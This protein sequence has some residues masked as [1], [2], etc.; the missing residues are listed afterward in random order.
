MSEYSVSQL[1]SLAGVSVRTLHYYDELGLLQPSGRS[2]AG[3]RVYNHAD[4][5]RLQQVLF[6]RELGV[7]LAEIP[8]LLAAPGFDRLMALRSHREQLQQRQA[9]L[10]QLIT[11]VD[12]SIQA[13]EEG[14]MGLSDEELFAG[15]TPEQRQRY[16]KE[17][18]ERW[19]EEVDQVESR[20]RKL[21]QDKWAGVQ[22]QGLAVTRAI[23]ELMALPVDDARVQAAIAKHH[24]W[25]ENFYP[26]SAER[27]IGLGQM[28]V[29]H[30][31]FRAY[32]D[33]V[34]PGLAQFMCE[35]MAVFAAQRL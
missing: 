23:A 32:Y 4:L 10:A 28:Y 15:F 9:Q 35:A 22:E 24:A 20:L 12:K 30:P 3:Y 29:E 26:C 27:Y 34:R 18:R 25:I 11:T 2:A 21:P 7:P 31:E 1:A 14:A 16:G 19:G 33:N 5:L 6:Y 8:S 17:A 13:M